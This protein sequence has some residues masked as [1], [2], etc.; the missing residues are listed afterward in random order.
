MEGGVGMSGVTFQ[1]TTLLK[2]KQSLSNVFKKR[3][4]EEID[5]DPIPLPSGPIRIAELAELLGGEGRKPK[6]LGNGWKHVPAE[7]IPDPRDPDALALAMTEDASKSTRVFG[8]AFVLTV[9][10]SVSIRASLDSRFAKDLKVVME[11]GMDRYINFM[12]RNLRLRLG[13]DGEAPEGVDGLRA[14]AVK[15]AAN[16]A[17]DRQDHYHGAYSTTAIGETT[18]KT[19]QI[20]TDQI[21]RELARKAQ[22]FPH[23]WPCT[24]S[25]SSP[26]KQFH[27]ELFAYCNVWI[28]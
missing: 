8:V 28:T 11:G 15:H 10:K 22:Q 3:R 9:K 4:E 18:G 24:I 25:S 13:K 12:E 14:W 6:L 21:T 16:S 2:G 23:F 1:T 7:K 19:G 5:L 27:N 26:T 17:G 20:D